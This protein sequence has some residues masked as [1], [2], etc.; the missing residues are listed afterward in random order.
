MI[1]VGIVRASVHRLLCDPVYMSLK[2]CPICVVVV[3]CFPRLT[4]NGVETCHFRCSQ[5]KQSSGCGSGP[6]S[7]S[8]M[9][10]HPL[11]LTQFSFSSILFAARNES[12]VI[13]RECI[14]T[15]FYTLVVWENHRP[16]TLSLSLLPFLLSIRATHFFW[17]K[18]RP[19]T[20]KLC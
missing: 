15:S 12:H 9:I 3:I 4:W 14:P 11:S 1:A 6:I 13:V 17:G 19:F 7:I 18:T 10:W 5:K 20:A 8:L 2:I 16:S